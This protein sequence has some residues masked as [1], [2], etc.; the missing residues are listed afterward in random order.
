MLYSFMI[1][2]S[3]IATVITVM[4]I[5][6]TFLK[7]ILFFGDHERLSMQAAHRLQDL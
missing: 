6:I 2:I 7:E 5:T 1:E 3:I 4:G